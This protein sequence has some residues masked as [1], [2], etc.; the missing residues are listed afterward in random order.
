ME[1]LSPTSVKLDRWKKYQLYEKAEVK[2]Y[3]L[4]DPVNES[5]EIY[6]LI[7]KHYKM[8]GVYTKDD[9]ISVHTLTG[10]QIDLNNIFI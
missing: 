5:L 3:W 8:Q 4:I 1:V 9:T 2:E 6:L 7:D 10:M